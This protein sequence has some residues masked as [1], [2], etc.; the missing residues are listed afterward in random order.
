M[1]LLLAL[2]LLFF[3]VDLFTKDEQKKLEDLDKYLYQVE[4]K[5]DHL[6]YH[7]GHDVTKHSAEFTPFGFTYV[8]KPRD[9]HSI[10]QKLKIVDYL[11]H[12]VNNPY[13]MGMMNP[14]MNMMMTPFNLGM[15]YHALTQGAH[16]P[17]L[18]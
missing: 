12:H 16:K 8:P 6:L 13:S 11:Q 7:H 17:N 3:R 15:G 9:P 5:I 10:H 18:I 4:D 1:K 14:M 2:F